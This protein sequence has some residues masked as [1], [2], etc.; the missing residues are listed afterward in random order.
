MGQVPNLVRHVLCAPPQSE[1]SVTNLGSK[2]QTKDRRGFA[3]W[4]RAQR[5]RLRRDLIAVTKQV[6]LLSLLVRDSRVPLPAK[7][8]G[9]CAIA[10][11]FSPIQ[12][13]P[14][15]IP[16]IG[17]LDD[18]AVVFLGTK[19]VRKLT[20]PNVLKECEERAALTLSV[21]VQKMQQILKALRQSGSV[22]A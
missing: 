13:I 4:W 7:I 14:T 15:F 5:S 6:E 12:L 2:E 1:S 11:I 20:P 10:Y 8:V 18:L 17:Q 3:S 19:V 22:A 21:R 9:G 16:L